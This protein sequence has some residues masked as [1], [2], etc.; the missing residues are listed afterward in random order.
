M[1]TLNLTEESPDYTVTRFPDGQQ[2]VTLKPDFFLN[3]IEEVTLKARLNNWLDLELICCMVASLREVNPDCKIH[4]FAPYIVGSRSDRKFEDG[5]NNYLRDVLCPVL[6]SLNLNS[7]TTLDPHSDVLEACLKRFRKVNN[8][9]LVEHAL[10]RIF[11]LFTKQT[12]VLIA[13]D[14]GASKKIYN[15]S[16]KTAYVNDVVICTKDRNLDGEIIHTN[17]PLEDNDLHTF[18]IIDDICDGGRTFIN[19]AENIKRQYAGLEKISPIKIYLIVTH[20]IFSK[21]TE[22]LAK[23][24]DG[25]YCTNSYSDITDNFLIKQLIVI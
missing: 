16:K 8:L 17:V 15:V 18:V 4:L 10:N 5:G 9:N 25:I 12:L 3:N 24:F 21:G 13:P 6:N 7:I 20:G 14:A 19:I 1:Y 22:E 23:Y 11:G 2:Q